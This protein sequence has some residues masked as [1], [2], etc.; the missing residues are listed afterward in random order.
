[1]SGD[2]Q[3]ERAKNRPLRQKLVVAQIN[4]GGNDGYSGDVHFNPNPTLGGAPW[5]DWGPYLWT[6]GVLGR[7]DGFLWCGGQPG[8]ACARNYDVRE[9]DL[10][11]ELDYWGDYTHPHANGQQKVAGQLVK[12]VQG[13][14]ASP[15]TYISDWLG[16]GTVNPWIQK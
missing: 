8:L 9:G 12:F 13:T 4:G 1:V 11:D 10:A 16:L 3:I 2:L 5:F 15:Q 6:N 7:S 14:L